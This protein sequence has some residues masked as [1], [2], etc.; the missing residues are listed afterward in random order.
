M[1]D[2]GREDG[3]LRLECACF[4]CVC[5]CV[6]I[7]ALTMLGWMVWITFDLCC[8]MLLFDAGAGVDIWMWDDFDD[9]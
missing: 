5:V 1:S 7:F 4:F 2:E 6:Y 8:L 3:K 9:T